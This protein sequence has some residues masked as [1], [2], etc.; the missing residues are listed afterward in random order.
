MT[1]LQL[2]VLG[3]VCASLT[4]IPPTQDKVEAEIRATHAQMK[5][6]AENLDAAALY[7]YV[8][9]TTT[10]PV[11]EDGQ[12]APT[13]AAALQRTTAGLQQVSRLSYTYAR[14]NVTVL[15]RNVALWV[16][17]GTASATLIDGRTISA[18]FAETI[19]FSR[20]DG[21]WTVRHAHR[22]TPNVR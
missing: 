20:E 13:H 21:R 7:S 14:D 10:P 19:V 9:N 16:A 17:E 1:R 6:A 11:I 5:L 18:P 4:Q 22:S 3:A 12:L 2:A 8:A 15:S